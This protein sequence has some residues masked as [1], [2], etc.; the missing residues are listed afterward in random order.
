MD[1]P[2]L[3][4]R[5]SRRGMPPSTHVAWMARSFGRRDL[6]PLRPD[7]VAALAGILRAVDVP[8]GTRLL[9]VG[10]PADTAYIVESGEV[11]IFTRRD[12]LR[13][14]VSIQR[15]GGVFGDVPLLCAMPFPFDAVA[16]RDAR[17]LEVGH[18][19]LIEVLSTHPA[20]G[21]RWLSSAVR[22][23]EHANRRLASLTTGDLG[24]RVAVLLADEVTVLPPPGRRTVDIE[25]TQGEIAALLGASRQSVN[26]I[27]REL[28]E[29]GI[30]STAYGRVVVEDAETLFHRAGL[31]AP[32]APSC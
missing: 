25:L 5:M 29:A 20:I 11:D 17:L 15:A 8:A 26:R 27:L 16:R 9:S 31:G 19:E 14:L 10:D 6:A 18:D 12:G 2:E 1:L 30:V 4:G 28:G 13:S 7:D 22:R 21:L 23:L 32:A 3:V 24:Q